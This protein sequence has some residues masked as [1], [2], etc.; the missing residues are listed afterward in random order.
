MASEPIMAFALLGLGIRSLSVNPA[1]LARIKLI[2]RGMRMSVAAA[3]ADAALQAP[4]AADSE[5]ILREQ[6][7]AEVDSE[8][9]H[10]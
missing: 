1:S 9:L 2:V 7:I 8:L 3:A 6:L 10:A 5:R 4:T